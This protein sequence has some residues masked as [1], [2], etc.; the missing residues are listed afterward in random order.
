MRCAARRA[1]D[2][3]LGRLVGCALVAAGMLVASSEAWSDADLPAAAEISARWHDRLDGRH[4]TA[5]VSLRIERENWNEERE[6]VVWRDDR[7]GRAERLMARFES[8][9]DLRGVGLLYLEREGQP[10]DYFL[11]QPSFGRVRRV[12]ETMAR[13][14]VYGVDLEVLGFGVARVAGLEVERAVPADLDGR[15]VWRV[16]ERARD[17]E[18]RFDRREVWLDAESFVPLRVEHHRAGALTMIAVTEEM[19]LVQG[20]ATPRVVRFERPALGER[21]Q[22]RVDEIDYE[23][24]IAEA[25]FS[26]MRLARSGGGAT[27]TA[28]A[29]R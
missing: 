21:V 29:G 22:M 3:V 28:A 11:Y 13:E 7:D 6:L 14:D 19:A 25:F 24:P 23:A 18:P 26:A 2:A 8:P 27:R 10:N 12:P 9:A 15:P 4:F 5:R 1:Y 17:P 20:V 16:T